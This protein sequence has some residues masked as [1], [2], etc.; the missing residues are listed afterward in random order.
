M[1]RLVRA[2]LS[3][4]NGIMSTIVLRTRVDES[5][6]FIARRVLARLGL[7]P[8]D[9]INAL[10]AQIA[11]RQAHPFSSGSSDSSYPKE[12]FGLDQE[13]VAAISARLRRQI[14][15]K[16]GSDDPKDPSSPGPG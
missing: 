8:A 5:N 4:H 2:K 3:I 1:L 10:F 7:E 14:A 15:G 12:E 11:R 9:A 13:T 6:A 16:R